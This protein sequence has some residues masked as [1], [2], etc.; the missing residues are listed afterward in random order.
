MHGWDLAVAT[1]QTYAVDDDL[2]VAAVGFVG[3]TAE[4]NPDGVPGPVRA[5]RC[6][7]PEDAP[8]LD[9]LLGSPGATRAGVRPDRRRVDRTRFTRR[10]GCRCP[11]ARRSC[12][13]VG[14]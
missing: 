7:C 11:P 14:R 8:P 9:R 12:A 5:G 6:R 1:G 3:P 2:A 10:A 4:Q 13:N